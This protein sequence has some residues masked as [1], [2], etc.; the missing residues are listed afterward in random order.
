VA[1]EARGLEGSVGEEMNGPDKYEPILRQAEESKDV[2]TKTSCILTCLRMMTTNDLPHIFRLQKNINRK[3]T[4][5]LIIGGT[6]L[7]LLFL[8]NPELF[9]M[10]GRLFSVKGV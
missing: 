2:E 9:A 1:R 7:V 5:A 4:W 10:I 8:C 6:L 3:L